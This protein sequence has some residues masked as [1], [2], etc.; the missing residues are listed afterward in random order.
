MIADVLPQCGAIAATPP[1]A[2]RLAALSEPDQD[3]VMELW[4]GA[5]ASHSV[6]LS[7]DDASPAATRPRFDDQGAVASIRARCGSP[8]R[9]ASRSACP[10]APRAC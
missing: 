2:K 8:G 7:R 4:R 1:H 5:F 9:C 3:A 10:T 6:I